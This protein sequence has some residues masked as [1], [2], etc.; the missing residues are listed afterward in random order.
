[1]LP[2]V[3]AGSYN[4]YKEDTA[5]FTTWLS[6]A[7]IACGYQA[8]KVAR[9]EK[10]EPKKQKDQGSAGRLKGKARKEAKEAAGASKGSPTNA[11]PSPPVTRYEITTQELLKQASA[12][13]ASKTS[14]VEIPQSIIRVAQRAINARR[15]CA[16]WFQKTG[17]KDE[18]GS[19]ARHINFVGVLEKALSALRPS[20]SAEPSPPKP[21]D[22]PSTLEEP[23]QE[24]T[25]RFGALIVEDLDDPLI[26]SAS[27]V[28]I[29]STK[30]AKGRSIDVYE[31][32]G[33]AEIDTAF[34]IF[35]FF[36]D[37]HRMQVDLKETWEGYKAGTCDLIVASVVTNLAFEL[38]RQA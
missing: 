13:A 33:Q 25:N 29:A 19:T 22:A 11:E 27:D 15:R 3:L 36:E 21:K 8:P 4:R 1:M 26:V 2:K 28:F 31:L 6:K 16:A 34:I 35:C 32:Q 18:D 12:V 5:V 30:S 24:L 14:G 17:V 20:G 37:L 7:A 10:T 23:S 38:V 9:Q